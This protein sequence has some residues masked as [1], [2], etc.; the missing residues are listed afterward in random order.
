MTS[1]SVKLNWLSA[2]EPNM[3]NFGQGIQDIYKSL[4]SILL[5]EDILNA[6]IVFLASF[7]ILMLMRIM[8][9]WNVHELFGILPALG[10]L[11]YVYKR[12]FD[13][14]RENEKLIVVEHVNPALSEKLRTAADNL[15]L[16]NAVVAELQE[17]VVHDLSQVSTSSFFNVRK[18][19]RKVLAALLLSIAII[20]IMY[21][22]VLFPSWT[23]VLKDYRFLTG[24]ATNDKSDSDTPSAGEGDFNDIFGEESIAQL[25]NQELNVELQ[26]LSFELTNVRKETDIPEGEF[27]DKFPDEVDLLQQCDSD[28]VL[29]NNIPIDKQELVKNYFI[30]LAE[31]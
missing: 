31:N 28:C 16:E 20:V 17:E 30:K 14:K 25:G 6:I 10:Y 29:R 7:L 1:T 22:S 3:K 24:G 12:D 27:E 4:D 15:Y 2:G 13:K 26:S 21:L 8:H 23:T 11:A 9:V 19:N 5:F 18:T